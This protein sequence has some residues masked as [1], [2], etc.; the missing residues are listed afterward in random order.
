MRMLLIL[1]E[2]VLSNINSNK[3]NNLIWILEH[4]DIYTAGTS[5]KKVKLLINQ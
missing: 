3:S 4:S 1:M 2:K 5:F